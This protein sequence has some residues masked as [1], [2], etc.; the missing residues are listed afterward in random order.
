MPLLA[1]MIKTVF[2]D[3]SPRKQGEGFGWGEPKPSGSGFAQELEQEC[4]VAGGALDQRS[5]GIR[6]NHLHAA[7]GSLSRRLARAAYLQGSPADAEV[8]VFGCV[9]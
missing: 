5:S 4:Y 6:H 8:V 3:V 7:N 2:I 1:P 9:W